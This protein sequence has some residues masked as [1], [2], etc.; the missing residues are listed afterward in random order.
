MSSVA[1]LMEWLEKM[2]CSESKVSSTDDLKKSTQTNLL[3]RAR[4][5]GSLAEEKGFDVPQ[6]SDDEVAEQ[7]IATLFWI[8]T[9]LNS[10]INE[11]MQQFL[12]E[13][14]T[15]SCAK[16]SKHS[17]PKL[18]PE[19]FSVGHQEF[20]TK[21]FQ[22][23]V[24]LGIVPHLTVGVGIPIGLRSKFANIISSLVKSSHIKLH[25][26]LIRLLPIIQPRN[27]RAV[28]MA[29][30]LGD[31]LAS[32]IQLRHA[33]I[34][35]QL[36]PAAKQH[37]LPAAVNSSPVPSDGCHS[38]CTIDY[39]RE[40]D[41]LLMKSYQPLIVRELL[42]LQ[43][44]AGA[45]TP[46]W[47]RAACGHFL[48]RILVSPDGVKYVI[49]GMITSDT[50]NWHRF[51]MVGRVIATPPKQWSADEYYRLIAPQILALL[52]ENY[53]VIARQYG[54]VCAAVLSTAAA[55]SLALMKSL[56]WIPLTQDLLSLC[57]NKQKACLQSIY[58]VICCAAEPQSLLLVCCLQNLPQIFS[59]YMTETTG[60]VLS[61]NRLCCEE[62]IAT[63]MLYAEASSIAAF[64]HDITFTLT[65]HESVEDDLSVE[66]QR[67]SAILFCVKKVKDTDVVE[68]YFISLLEKL[69]Q[70]LSETN[71][72]Q[73]E[74][75]MELA[76]L[77]IR[78][79][80]M[81]LLASLCETHSRVCLKHPCYVIN[82]AKSALTN[83]LSATSFIEDNGIDTLNLSFG[84][85]T[86]LMSGAA[87]VKLTETDVLLLKE[88]NDPLNKLSLLGSVPVETRELALNIRVAIATQGLVWMDKLS[89]FNSNK[90][91]PYQYTI[92]DNKPKTSTADDL[93]KGSRLYRSRADGAGKATPQP[94]IS[95]DSST[96][97]VHAVDTYQPLQNS[98]RNCLTSS[99]NMQ[100]VPSASNCLTSSNIEQQVA[101]TSNG[102]TSSDNVQQVPSTS[103][104]LK[105]DAKGTMTGYKHTLMELGDHLVPVK[106]HALIQLCKYIERKDKETMDNRHEL[107][108]LL[109][110]HL[111]HSDSY[112]YLSAI[113]ALAALADVYPAEVLP[114]LC[115][116]YRNANIVGE[117]RLKVGEVITK[118]TRQ[119]GDLAPSFSNII[120]PSI[121]IG[122][123]AKDDLLRASSL[124]N[125]GEL[126]K[127][128]H[129]SMGNHVYE[130]VEC[131]S[132]SLIDHCQSSRKGAAYSIAL[133][134]CELNTRCFEVLGA[135]C[136]RTLYKALKTCVNSE[137]D[138]V[139]THHCSGAIDALDKV[140]KQLF[141]SDSNKLEKRIFVL[142][143]PS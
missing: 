11:E 28:F 51:Q 107:Q 8:L 43:S 70:L 68:D 55:K 37:T 17:A 134:I 139:T 117:T 108:K 122:C 86:A 53:E 127:L 67:S 126:C 89:Q 128:L 14:R 64:L 98:S 42:V 10:T 141:S 12:L 25:E 63:C 116:Q 118:A 29:R 47:M 54:R 7:Y 33:Q 26:N 136:M 131:L 101:S 40:L 39:S 31:L 57:K 138:Q 85:L 59:I 129:Y 77:M 104:C 109:I 91:T 80:V 82:F 45:Q 121:L 124:V 24:S 100:Q 84:L 123:K 16:E 41:V 114:P 71:N 102:L 103:K 132:A 130:I 52:R 69:T 2:V 62:I 9:K 95:S 21:V 142:D 78:L 96:P 1:L 92:N 137:N 15:T 106:G 38:N 4:S 73:S 13:E 30:H 22:F 66:D 90:A 61:D 135:D 81:S 18:S 32:L 46:A 50:D 87:D 88:L 143:P 125:L 74:H 113:S 35:G 6:V 65:S 112:I 36:A 20:L 48:T 115:Q 23:I 27:M 133:I 58:R 72:V 119:L 34:S 44:A 99:D 76:D 75:S 79:R 83:F 97:V 93:P 105:A 3:A 5:I 94:Q 140:T 60:V 56:F 49:A 111:S 110:E 19:I 120:L